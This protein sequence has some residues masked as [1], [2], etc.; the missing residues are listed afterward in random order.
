ML[1][2]KRFIMY[3][4]AVICNTNRARPSVCLSGRE[5]TFSAVQIKILIADDVTC[6]GYRRNRAYLKWS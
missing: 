5:E 2:P 1:K 3:V 6:I 4:A